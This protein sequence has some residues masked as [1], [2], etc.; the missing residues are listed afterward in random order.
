MTSK[1]PN[2][3]QTPLRGF[4]FGLRI[5][6]RPNPRPRNSLYRGAYF[7]PPPPNPKPRQT[8]LILTLLRDIF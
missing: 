6:P 8:P 1:A 2:P 3:A 5:K 7:S 4:F